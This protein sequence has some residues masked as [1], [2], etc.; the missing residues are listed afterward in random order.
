[1][2]AVSTEK[3]VKFFTRAGI[4]QRAAATYAL[5]FA[6]NR[7]QLDMLL[8]LNKEY[9]RDMG[10]TLM[11]DVIAI[12]RHARQVHEEITHERL[13]LSAKGPS[14]SIKPVSSNVKESSISAGT[15]KLL[16]GTKVLK[17]PSTSTS[18]SSFNSSSS[19]S[20]SSSAP[21]PPKKV[22]VPS[23]IS[24]PNP[25]P[26]PPGRTTA[27]SSALSRSM[28]TSSEKTS[29]KKTE[30]QP[31]SLKRRS[32]E[33]S[34]SKSAGEKVDLEEIQ[35]PVKKVRRVLPEHEG[36]YKIKM[37]TGSTPRSQQILA[38][39]KETAS[40]KTVFDRLGGSTSPV[41]EPVTAAV[42]A[43]SSTTSDPTF[44]ITGL[45]GTKKS[46]ITSVFSRLG[47]KQVSSTSIPPGTEDN[48]SHPGILKNTVTKPVQRATV[49][50]RTSSMVADSLSTANRS[51]VQSRIGMTKDVTTVKRSATIVSIPKQDYGIK[52]SATVV[53][54]PRKTGEVKRLATVLPGSKPVKLVKTEGILAGFSGEISRSVKSRLGVDETSRAPQT[55]RLKPVPR[56]IGA[57]GPIKQRVDFAKMNGGGAASSI[58]RVTFSGP[59]P[60]EKI[61]SK[62]GVFSR[63]G[64]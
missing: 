62:S 49:V 58:K 36:G 61:S 48:A 27:S 15:A 57:A 45:E 38:K 2:A 19:S 3:W 21:S 56:V 55:V 28:G 16:K 18:S 59:S 63:L 51:D 54:I 13:L 46:K 8:D 1:M 9:L 40:K 64:R 7:I 23:R 10:I 50:A 30:S 32:G 25:R 31:E 5:T 24:D 26:V 60:S 33:I 14:S 34:R 52:R 41:T 39:Q 43:V 53:M 20:Q 4:P 35:V 12:L 37:P 44:T 11:G 47:D 42:S 22:S 6:D 17:A 29:A